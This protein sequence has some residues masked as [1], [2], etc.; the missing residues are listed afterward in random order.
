METSDPINERFN[1]MDI[2]WNDIKQIFTKSIFF[3]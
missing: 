3:N 1:E 2:F